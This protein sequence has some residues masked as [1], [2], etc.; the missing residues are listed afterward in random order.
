MAVAR[1]LR[2]LVQA[3]RTDVRQQLKDPRI[4]SDAMDI[5]AG[6]QRTGNDGSC[7]SVSCAGST[8][9]PASASTAVC[10]AG[11]GPRA[12]P[13]CPAIASAS[14][15]A[16]SQEVLPDM[17]VLNP[18]EPP[19]R[20]AGRR[21]DRVLPVALRLGGMLV[22]CPKRG[23]EPSSR[24]PEAGGGLRIR[25]ERLLGGNLPYVQAPPSRLARLA[26]V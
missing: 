5:T 23:A 25:P 17:P 16:R 22:R 13:P 15:A 6:K 8:T 26:D 11:C 7:T 14:I 12:A 19:G 24:P 20:M 10:A 1:T 2:E 21:R 18:P 9:P 4:R 3:N